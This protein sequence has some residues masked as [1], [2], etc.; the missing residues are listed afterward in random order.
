MKP[1]QLFPGLPDTVEAALRVSI[2]R[3][4]VI[5]PIVKDQDGNILDGHHRKRIADEL[6]VGCPVDERFVVDDGEARA[7]AVTLNTDRRHLSVEQRREV[8]MALRKD[9]H[10]L[11]AIAG[12]VGV[13][14]A[15]VRRDLA[16][17][18]SDTPA[19][20]PAQ[21]I[22]VLT[23]GLDGKRYPAQAAP[24]K[25]TP[26]MDGGDPSQGTYW[27]QRTEKD[28]RRIYQGL[29]S[30]KGAVTGLHEHAESAT[31]SADHD[32]IKAWRESAADCIRELNKLR[33]AL[34]E[35]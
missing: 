21:S 27:R 14:H 9:G 18:S 19:T 1:Y 26:D 13:V 4:G 34:G 16:G 7:L 3:F 33:R 15:T 29:A 20:K 23:T 2:E 30:A 17:V 32:D 24:P 12:A 6:G 11:R 31:R 28:K 25:P 5:V 10:S 35:Q 22:P 8:V